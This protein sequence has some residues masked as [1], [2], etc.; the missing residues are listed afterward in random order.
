M[1][2]RT[3]PRTRSHPPA[4]SPKRISGLIARDKSAQQSAKR[5]GALDN[6]SHRTDRISA[7][8]ALAAKP[9]HQRPRQLQI[10][11]RRGR[12]RHCHLAVRLLAQGSTVLVRHANRMRSLLGYPGVVDDPCPH[13]S[14]A[15]KLWQG[16]MNLP[17][18]GGHLSC[19]DYR[20]G[21]EVGHGEEASSL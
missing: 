5:T 15:F 21:P 6:R 14:V 13:G 10:H 18:F 17:R 1:R 4:S 2:K 9:Q 7:A 20:S 12:N 16:G 3:A 19:L 8:R 11:V